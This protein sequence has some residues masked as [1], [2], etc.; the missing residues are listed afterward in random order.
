MLASASFINIQRA[1]LVHKALL[2]G[3]TGEARK[4]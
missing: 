2:H 1:A 3:A 4:F